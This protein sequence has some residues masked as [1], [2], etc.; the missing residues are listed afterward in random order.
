MKSVILYSLIMGETAY[1]LCYRK[2]S[3]T[4]KKQV[5][6]LVHTQEEGIPQRHESQDVGINPNHLRS[7]LPQ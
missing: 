4:E 6:G 3:Y 5:I 2:E 1:Q 7:Y